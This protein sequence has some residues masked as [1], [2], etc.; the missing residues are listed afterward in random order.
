MSLKIVSR[1]LPNAGRGYS[2]AG[3]GPFPAVLLLHGSAGKWSGW[4]HKEAA[5]LAAH[6]FLTIPF[7]YSNGGNHWNAGDII[8]VPLNRTA[9]AL[10][11]ACARAVGQRDRV[12]A[13][14]AR[15]RTRL[16]ACLADGTR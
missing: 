4:T 11:A 13:R 14:V 6:G 15:R 10:A 5:I 2:P 8:N 7:G 16:A 1:S 3:E 12:L 9:E